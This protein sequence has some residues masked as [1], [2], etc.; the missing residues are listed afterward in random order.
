[1]PRRWALI[2]ATLSFAIPLIANGAETGEATIACMSEN[3]PRRSAVLELRLESVDRSGRSYTHEGRVFWELAPD[4][5]SRTLVCMT[6]PRDVEG[7]AYLIHNRESERQ[8]WLYLPEDERVLRYTPGAAARRGRI[9]R[10]A[11]RYDD[12]RYLP[13]NL[14]QA[15]L[16]GTA[17][18]GSTPGSTQ[19]ELALPS[20][21]KTDYTRVRARID[22]ASCVPIEIDLYES[23]AKP[24]KRVRTTRDDIAKQGKTH[25]MRSATVTDDNH[26][27]KTTVNTKNLRV[28]TDLPDEIFTPQHLKRRQC[29]K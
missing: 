10:T 24:R 20:G 7:L 8:I 9:G 26:G 4:G 17:D 23:D 29:P 2:L 1:M 16:D 21:G 25:Y 22:D 6:A 12:L 14:A 11:I 27:V 3:V 19:V 15:T 13:L 5:L 28:D 18:K